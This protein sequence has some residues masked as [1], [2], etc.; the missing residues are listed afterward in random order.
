MQHR[1]T[2]GYKAIFLQREHAKAWFKLM[3]DDPAYI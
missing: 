1:A 3:D 2:E